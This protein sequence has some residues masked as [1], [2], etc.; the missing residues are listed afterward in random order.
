MTLALIGGAIGLA[1]ALL[2][3]R[4]LRSLLFGVEPTDAATF[5]SVAVLLGVIAFV[6]CS[7]PARRASRVDPMTAL[8]CD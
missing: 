1:G 2:A 3:T 7:I 8:R 5:V 4:Y 6:A